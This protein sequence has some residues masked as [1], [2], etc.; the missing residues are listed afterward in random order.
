[1]IS[2]DL[3]NFTHPYYVSTIRGTFLKVFYSL[4]YYNKQRLQ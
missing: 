2:A 4:K 3:R 1:M